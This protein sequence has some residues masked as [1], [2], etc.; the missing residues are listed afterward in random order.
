M[1]T[2]AELVAEFPLRPIRNDRQLRKASDLAGQLAMHARL[3][4]DE[5]DYLE[6]LSQ[7][8]ETYEDEH[9]SIDDT[10]VSPRDMLEF[11][12]ENHGITLS[13]LAEET[14]IKGSTLSNILHGKR[15]LNI[16]HEAAVV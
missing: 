2:Y 12:V 4:R 3:S 5:H 1:S 13:R 7:I 14:G 6:V 15:E 16:E 10:S 11:L 9:H 8:I